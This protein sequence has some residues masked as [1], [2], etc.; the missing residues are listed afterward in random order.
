MSDVEHN[1][2]GLLRTRTGAL[3]TTL[4]LR[5]NFVDDDVFFRGFAECGIQPLQQVRYGFGFSADQSSACLF[6][7]G[8]ECRASDRR[9]FTDGGLCRLYSSA[10]T[11]LS[12]LRDFT[13]HSSVVQRKECP[14]AGVAALVY[15]ILWVKQPALIVGGSIGD[16]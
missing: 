8:G 11:K 5:Q 9:D 1:A 16:D 2:A 3:P 6:A 15:P 14:A 13:T 10:S 4:N 12:R 7:D